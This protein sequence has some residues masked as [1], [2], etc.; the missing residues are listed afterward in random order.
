MFE[1]Q[2]CIGSTMWTRDYRRNLYIGNDQ[3]VG[4]KFGIESSTKA[5]ELFKEERREDEK[6]RPE[7]E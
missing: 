5:G 1:L 4:G 2:V 3:C 6:K 7:E